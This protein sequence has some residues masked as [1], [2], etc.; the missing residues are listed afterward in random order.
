MVKII[1]AQ[2]K[3]LQSQLEEATGN[4]DIFLFD[5][6]IERIEAKIEVLYD[7]LNEAIIQGVNDPE[8]FNN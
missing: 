5:P 6:E 8:L 7:V 3:Q 1:N 2:L 4:G